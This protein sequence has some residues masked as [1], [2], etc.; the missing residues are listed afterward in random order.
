M[1]T[2]VERFNGIDR[3]AHIPAGIVQQ[4]RTVWERRAQ[5]TS[6]FVSKQ[7]SVLSI[8]ELDNAAALCLFTS[9]P[10]HLLLSPC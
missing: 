4:S 6:R 9:T 2:R 1:L 8:K 10:A 7:Q 3:Q 5:V